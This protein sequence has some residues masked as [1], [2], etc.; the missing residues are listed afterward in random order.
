MMHPHAALMHFLVHQ[1]VNTGV[2]VLPCTAAA[3]M[4]P[5]AVAL[6]PVLG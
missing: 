4:H 3:F 5:T 6:K 1:Y 2:F